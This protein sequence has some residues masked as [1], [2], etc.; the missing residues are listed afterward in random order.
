MKEAQPQGHQLNLFGGPPELVGGPAEEYPAEIKDALAVLAGEATPSERGGLDNLSSTIPPP[1]EPDAQ[2]RWKGRMTM[3]KKHEQ[4]SVITKLSEPNV[5]VLDIASEEGEKE[6][7]R[8]YTLLGDPDNGYAGTEQFLKTV[9]DPKAPRG[10]R[11]LV[12]VRW[13]KPVKD[14]RKR[15]EQYE[16]TESGQDSV[17]D[18]IK[19][20]VAEMRSMEPPTPS[21]EQQILRD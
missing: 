16:S 6:L 7:V 3:L 20:A 17:G 21:G 13:W 14:L 5:R 18:R 2:S 8:I 19:E 4:G 1:G 11:A 10:F 9:L 12:M 15:P